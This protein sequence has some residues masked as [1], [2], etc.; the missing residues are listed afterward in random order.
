ME[1]I[2]N[3]FSIKSLATKLQFFLIS[4]NFQKF[5]HSQFTYDKT[6][7]NK[8]KAV[9]YWCT[10]YYAYRL[11]LS[12]LASFL[13]EWM[14]IFGIGNVLAIFLAS[15]FMYVDILV[16]VVISFNR[17]IAIV[18]P[19]YYDKVSLFITTTKF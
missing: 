13:F 7:L 1:K 11:N 10:Y 16:S 14:P 9:S 17:L 8:F 6:K 3:I 15:Y 12:S 18:F 2:L 4:A 19:F 5:N